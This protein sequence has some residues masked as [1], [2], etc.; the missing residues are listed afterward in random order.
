MV[1]TILVTV[2]SSVS[3]SMKLQFE[4]IIPRAWTTSAFCKLVDTTD[5]LTFSVPEATVCVVSESM[6]L[7]T[8][9]DVCQEDSQ[10]NQNLTIDKVKVQEEIWKV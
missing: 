9:G 10:G 2:K 3:S 7:H 1:V 6:T 5:S 8:G 4:N